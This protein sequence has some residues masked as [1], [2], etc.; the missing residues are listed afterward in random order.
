MAQ[1][2]SPT[3]A[4]VAV[5]TN[6]L[7][8]NNISF[9]EEST[10]SFNDT[11]ILNINVAQCNSLIN[12]TMYNYLDANDNIYIWS[13]GSSFV[14]N[15]VFGLVDMVI[16]LVATIPFYM[17]T[18]PKQTKFSVTARKSSKTHIGSQLVSATS[19]F[20]YD[21][22]GIPNRLNYVYNQ[23]DIR[24]ATTGILSFGYYFSPQDILTSG[25]LTGFTNHFTIDN[26]GSNSPNQLEFPAD[27]TFDQIAG[28]YF[29]STLDVQSIL[30]ANP[31]AETWYYQM[32]AQATILRWS[33]DFLSSE[34]FPK[35]YPLVMVLL[36]L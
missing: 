25:K 24:N 27:W 19:T 34:R 26:Y 17:M 32:G 14:P 28:S 23:G 5:I 7:N 15:D 8:S 22:Y 33:L 1:M 20:L 29:E 18:S 36:S 16:N 30:A 13:Y 31:A 2:F 12:T 4:E 10:F 11:F 9:I 3:I 6:W 35:V 21:Q